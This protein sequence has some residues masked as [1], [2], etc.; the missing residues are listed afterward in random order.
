MERFQSTK[1]I[2]EYKQKSKNANTTKTTTQ[3][4]RVF[5]Q[6]A[7]KRDHPKNIEVLAPDA[8]DSILQHFFAEINKKD[9]KDYKPSSLAAMQSSIGRYLFESNYEYSILNSR[10]FK[11]SRD[12]LEGKARLLRQ[13]GLGKKPNKTNSLKRQEEDILWECGQPGDKTPL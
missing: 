6:L 10:F 3:W 4:M 7:Q 11:G 9:G 5:C 8:L 13:K 2:E 1:S 12:V